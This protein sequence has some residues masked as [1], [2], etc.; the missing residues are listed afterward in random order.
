ME[1]K[2]RYRYALISLIILMS[3]CVA[4]LPN[5]LIKDNI[6]DD[7]ISFTKDNFFWISPDIWLD[8]NGDG[9]PDEMAKIGKS[10]KLFARIHNIGT[11]EARDVK[12]KFYVNRG[13]TYFSF[14]E[15]ALIGTNVISNIE[16]GETTI[17]S[18]SWENVNEANCWSY[19]VAVESADDPIISNEPVNESN[20]AYRSFWTV[21]TYS[22]RPVILKFRIQN[23]LSVKTRVNLTLDT[24]NLPGK[25]GAFLGKGSFELRAKESKPVLLMVTPPINS[26]KKE[27]LLNVISTIEDRIIGG[28]TYKIK[29][30]E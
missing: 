26:E 2:M 19:G 14:T 12:V 17:T 27:A 24:Q 20:L 4:P 8:N 25:W 22:G 1:L 9:Q 11:A 21:Y 30:K 23:P 28:I 29:I 6:R 3:G 10:N 16:A 7:G 15:G 13:N 5:L 18:I